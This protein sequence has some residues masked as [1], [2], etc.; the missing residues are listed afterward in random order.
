MGHVLIDATQLYMADPAIYHRMWSD[1]RET[2]ITKLGYTACG[3]PR[4]ADDRNHDLPIGVPLIPVALRK[5]LRVARPCRRC[6][7]THRS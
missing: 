6:F 2:Y 7:P 1:D 5:A 3:L 4:N